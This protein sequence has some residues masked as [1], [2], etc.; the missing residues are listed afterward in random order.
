MKPKGRDEES[1]D[2][3][4]TNEFNW[5]CWLSIIFFWVWLSIFNCLFSASIEL[6]DFFKLSSSV[7]LFPFAW[8]LSNLSIFSRWIIKSW[9][10][11]Y[12]K[13]QDQIPFNPFSFSSILLFNWLIVELKIS[14]KAFNSSSTTSTGIP[15]STCT[16]TWI[17]G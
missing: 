4:L 8:S 5:A 13:L 12:L 7:L 9:F 11:V 10:Y 3:L 14:L 16:Y 2:D 6:I 17:P 15:A 1:L